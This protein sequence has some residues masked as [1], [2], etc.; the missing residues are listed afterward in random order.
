MGGAAD[1]APASMLPTEC[2]G[3][4]MPPRAL[5]TKPG[6]HQVGPQTA[7]LPE[8]WPTEGWR[9]E[10]PDK[11]GFDPQKLA[12]ALEFDT[13][14]ASTQAIFIVRHGYVA[15]EKYIGSFTAT[16]RHDSFSMAKSF[17][18]GLI[19]IAIAEGKI[20]STDAKLCEY[21]PM[22]WDCSDTKDPRSRI[23]IEH[24]MNL[25]TGLRWQE[26]WRSGATGTN[27]AL[28]A[29]MVNTA[30]ARESVAEPGS[31]K[32][33]STGDPSLLVG[34]LEQSVGMTAFEYGKQ[35][36]FDLIGIPDVRWGMDGSGRTT[37]YAG[38]QATASEFAKYGYLLLNNGK[39]DGKQVIPGEWIDR[40]TKPAKPCEDWN[41]WLWHVNL[42]LRLGKQ[43]S[44]CVNSGKAF[45][46]P[47][48]I[49]DLPADGFMAKGINGQYIVIVPSAD[50]VVVRLAADFAGSERW[51]EYMRGL[52]AGIFDAMK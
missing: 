29:G 2:N 44:D 25:T 37:V 36:L 31:M 13:E 27:D 14:N 49:A 41:Q 15:A 40:T 23:T 7:G 11:L 20:P 21:Y 26:D 24:A 1:P 48:D 3:V 34:P 51:D 18:S 22:Q 33:Y 43:P 28:N 50:L 5:A 6:P 52:L 47:T 19:G 35:K 4:A 46:S 42:P 32:R 17:T 9:M 45:C 16:S 38:L 10:M 8:Y 30:L 39:W 12:T